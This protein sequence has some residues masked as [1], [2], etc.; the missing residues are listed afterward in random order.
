MKMN[1]HSTGHK[2]ELERIILS[3]KVG[4][5]TTTM[6]L[7][8]LDDTTLLYDIPRIFIFLIKIIIPQGYI[9]NQN[10]TNLQQKM[11]F[12]KLYMIN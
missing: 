8:F 3:L 5:I 12:F 2:T 7:N 9:K 11:H 4:N 1:I 10:T 6:C